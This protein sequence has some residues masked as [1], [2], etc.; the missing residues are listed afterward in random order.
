MQD[1][2]VLSEKEVK[3]AIAEKYNVP[4][5][6]VMNLKYSYIIIKKDGEKNVHD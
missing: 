2:N 6:N 3:E 4:L 1:A 5:E